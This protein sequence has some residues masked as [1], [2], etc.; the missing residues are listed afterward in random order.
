MKIRTHPIRI[1][2][3]VV[4][5]IARRVQYKL[6]RIRIVDVVPIDSA[7]RVQVV[8]VRIRVVE[9]IRRQ[10]PNQKPKPKAKTKNQRSNLIVDPKLIY[11]NY[12]I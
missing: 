7:S 12:I 6:I 8:Q 4:A 11:I 10:S 5:Q 1:V 3:V 9:V 2:D